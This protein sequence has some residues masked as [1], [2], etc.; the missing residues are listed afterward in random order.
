M[1][2]GTFENTDQATL[3]IHEII[4]GDYDLRIP[5]LSYYED[6]YDEADEYVDLD[7]NDQIAEIF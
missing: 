4:R 2:L 3:C 6:G 5:P 7:E 1:I